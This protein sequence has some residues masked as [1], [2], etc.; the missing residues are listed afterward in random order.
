MHAYHTPWQ[1]VVR[2]GGCGLT[3]RSFVYGHPLSSETVDYFNMYKRVFR[4]EFPRVEDKKANSLYVVQFAGDR[5]MIEECDDG[6][7]HLQPY[8]FTTYTLNGCLYVARR[9]TSLPLIDLGG[10]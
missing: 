7:T 10:V 4:E 1:D 6:T 2:S 8:H 5:R 9:V 3:D